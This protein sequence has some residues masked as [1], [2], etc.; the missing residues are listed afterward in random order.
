M[1]HDHMGLFHIYS[2]FSWSPDFSSFFSTFSSVC[3]VVSSSGFVS[4]SFSIDLG[5]SDC[6]FSLGKVV[7]SSTL[8]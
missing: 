1:S 3:S 4:P 8:R 2:S 6:T 7:L 5:S